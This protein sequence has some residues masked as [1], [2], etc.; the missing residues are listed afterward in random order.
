MSTRKT[1]SRQVLHPLDLDHAKDH[2]DFLTGNPNASVLIVTKDDDGERLKRDSRLADAA[3]KAGESLDFKTLE[4]PYIASKAGRL[5]KLARWIEDRQRLGC[6][7][8]VL[9]NDNGGGKARTHDAIEAVRALWHEDDEKRDA[10]R[11]D[12]PLPPSFDVQSSPGKYHSYWLI[13]EP[14]TLDKAAFEGCQLRIA[15]A[16]A[17]DKGAKHLAQILRLAGS[18]NLK[19]GREPWQAEAY[20]PEGG[21][22]LYTAAELLEAFPP[23][24]KE[25][26]R[27]AGRAYDPGGELPADEARVRSALD[28]IR[29]RCEGQYDGWLQIGMAL[30]D[31]SGGSVDALGLWQDFCYDADECED[32]WSTFRGRDGGVSVGTIFHHAEEA[33][34]SS[35][36]GDQDAFAHFAKVM[37]TFKETGETGRKKSDAGSEADGF[38]VLVEL[39]AASNPTPIA[40][41]L[42]LKEISAM[43]GAPSIPA[44]RKELAQIMREQHAERMAEAPEEDGV[45]FPHI[46]EQD[47][48]PRRDSLPNANVWADHHAMNIWWDEFADQLM[49]DDSA[50]D[51][52][53]LHTLREGMH[54]DRFFA[55]TGF[56]AEALTHYGWQRRRHPAREYFNRVRKRWDGVER[57]DTWLIDYCGAPDNVHWRA[58]GRLLMIAIV[59]R[60][61]H[62]GSKFDYVLSLIGDEG[63]GKS[64]FCRALAVRDEWCLE[65]FQLSWDQ[66]KIIENTG[67]ILI[68]EY[69]EMA[70]HSQREQ[71][72]LKDAVSRT[73]DK[74]RKA[75]GRFAETRL[76]SYVP[77]AT[78]NESEPLISKWGNRRF[79]PLLVLR[80]IDVKGLEAMLDQLYGEAVHAQEAYLEE[81]GTDLVLAREHWA[82][83][84]ELQEA[85]RLKAPVEE[86]VHQ[87]VDNIEE[88][89]MASIEL[90]NVLDL[91]LQDRYAG[92]D[93]EHALKIIGWKKVRTRMPGDTHPQRYFIKGAH[94]E[95][96][97]IKCAEDSRGKVLVRK[98]TGERGTVVPFPKK[99]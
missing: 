14:S 86:R 5:D 88:G 78:V 90:F 12:F 15:D 54:Q 43:T 42:K 82:Y 96:T 10:P 53:I 25:K 23:M 21:L 74:A 16:W 57:L 30:H 89:H 40:A 52:N 64:S 95:S 73:K 46:N 71:A 7:V 76:R 9:V 1:D 37:K 93:I 11:E 62:P 49:L 92:A 36:K 50:V 72:A 97:Q 32:K 59:M 98:S 6:G 47:G 85:H 77:I 79:W 81:H 28:A 45:P 31:W 66:K 39:L 26:G 91:K 70:G 35:A 80:E 84:G 63:F 65:G 68:A 2:I 22:A 87:L 67:G 61:R 44:L 41:D 4:G 83:F 56:A 18:W 8:F 19:P 48:L 75:Y 20:A 99:E 69:G 17:G 33:G 94:P 3:R 58:A 38:R 51:D 13:D 34:W 29:E 60:T 27:G 55:S 24:A